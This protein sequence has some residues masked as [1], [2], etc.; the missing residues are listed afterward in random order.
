[1]DKKKEKKDDM[2]IAHTT[3]FQQLGYG[4]DPW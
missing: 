2:T 3:S 4:E 1:V